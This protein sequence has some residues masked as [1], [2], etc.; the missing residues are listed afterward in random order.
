MNKIGKKLHHSTEDFRL[1]MSYS[2]AKSIFMKCAV[3]MCI[4]MQQQAGENSPAN[5]LSPAHPM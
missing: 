1:E 4:V 2:M 3:G 5:C